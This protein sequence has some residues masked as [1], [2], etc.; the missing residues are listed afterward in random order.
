MG[1]LGPNKLSA[2]FHENLRFS[3]GPQILT[4]STFAPRLGA[5]IDIHENATFMRGGRRRD[6]RLRHR[7]PPKE[8]PRG[9]R[10]SIFDPPGL[11]L[12]LFG[13]PW[14]LIF[15]LFGPSGHLKS[16]PPNGEA[17]TQNFSRSCSSARPSVKKKK[18]CN[19]GSLNPWGA[20]GGREAIRIRRPPL[21][22]RSVFEISLPNAWPYPPG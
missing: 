16:A 9:L 17:L 10:R 19:P 12:E 8:P 2:C 20:A 15:K 13:S 7:K 14:G 11:I 6:P 18:F 21:A 4:F 22:G 5:S 1:P 3:S